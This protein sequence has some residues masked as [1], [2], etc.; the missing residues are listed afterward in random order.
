MSTDAPHG[1][2]SEYSAC[3]AEPISRV[4][5]VKVSISDH[6]IVIVILGESFYHVVA[7]FK[8]YGISFEAIVIIIV[9]VCRK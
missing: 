9:L 2:T 7:P 3:G 1:T 6:V 8:P 4:M 5:M